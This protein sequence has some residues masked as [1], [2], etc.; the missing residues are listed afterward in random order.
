MGLNEEIKYKYFLGENDESLAILREAKEE[1]AHHFDKVNALVAKHGFD[2]AWGGRS[3][4][5]AF[6]AKIEDTKAEMKEGFLKPKIKRSEGQRYAVYS[7]DKRYKAGKDIA[8]EMKG[9]GAF[10]F[11]DFIIEKL[12]VA[13]LVFGQMDGRQVMCSTSAGNYG[14]KLVVRLPTGGDSHR[15]EITIPSFLREIKKSE[16]IAI[17]EESAI[18]SDYTERLAA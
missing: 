9:V 17:S 1:R 8:K 6:A 11:S 7:P 14:N 2:C 10:N 18:T 3:E 5:T 4:I 15:R 13:A 16:F 12:G